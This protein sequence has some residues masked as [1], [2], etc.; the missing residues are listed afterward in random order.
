MWNTDWA[1]ATNTML[2]PS[3]DIASCAL[4]LVPPAA[5]PPKDMFSGGAM[6]NSTR[7]DAGVPG[8]DS[9]RATTAVAVNAIA[10][11]AATSHARRVDRDATIGVGAR[12]A[13]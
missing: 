5:G 1:P 13:W 11:S 9:R 6:V 12:L 2:R 4:L 3:G 7:S 10:D 8:R